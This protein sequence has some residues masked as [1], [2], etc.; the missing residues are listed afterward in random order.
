MSAGGLEV[1]GG[2]FCTEGFTAEGEVRM[3]GAKLGANLAL[4]GAILRNP[5]KIA[6]DLDRAVM[7]H[8]NTAR[9]VCTGQFTC[10]ATQF[11]SG[12][13]LDD[14]RLDGGE[15]RPAL[16]ADG[17]IVNG[18]LG[19]AGLRAQGELSF[20]STKVAQRVRL[21]NGH[22]HNPAGIALRFSQT[23]VGTDILCNGMTVTGVTKLAGSKITGAVNLEHVQ[24]I[25]PAKVALDARW[26]QAGTVALLPEEPIQGL[27]DLSHARIG[28]LIDEPQRWPAE[29]NLSSL[30]YQ[31]LEPQ[32]PARDRLR[33][34][35]RNRHRQEPQPYEQLASCYTAI[36]QPGQARKVLYARE[37]Q[38]RYG[39]G[40]LARAWSR[41]QDLTVGYGYQPWRA[42]L[43][44]ALL[45]AIGS[46]VFHLSPP[47]PLQPNAAPHFNPVV[48]TL[49]LLLPVVN[50]GQKYAFNPAGAEQWFS[51]ALIAAGWLLATTIAAGLA[52]VLTRS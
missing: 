21:D 5:G 24:L 18:M 41:L 52:R 23:T 29:L 35:T 26:L 4:V 22:V 37:R 12:L 51:Y 43:W 47:A 17:A 2:V 48:Y 14:A 42:A 33:W 32:L 1:Q 25:N 50:L 7:G 40:P 45:L 13:S 6:L 28:V 16:N 38:Q 36:G 30:T 3:V 46:I 27:V 31:A 39:K 11:G 44:L 15:D 9:L 19:M 34:L 49:D 8:C 20:R 10:V